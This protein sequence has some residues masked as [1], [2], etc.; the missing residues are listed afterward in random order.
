LKWNLKQSLKTRYNNSRTPTKAEA[1]ME[2][3]LKE[4]GVRY[5]PQ[6]GFFKDLNTFFI[7][8]FY[9]PRPHKLVIEVDGKYHE[10]RRDYDTRR[11]EYLKSRGFR[12]L[13]IKNEEI[14]NTIDNVKEILYNNI[15]I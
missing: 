8:D 14:L 6:K 3:L 9:L 11:D 15:N 1:A 13:R 10:D 5:I 4:V 7:V 2:T 12:V